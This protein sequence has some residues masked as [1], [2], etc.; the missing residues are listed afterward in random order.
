VTK[1]LARLV[2]LSRFNSWAVWAVVSLQPTLIAFGHEL[3]CHSYVGNR[4]RR[5]IA[6]LVM[7]NETAVPPSS[8]ARD[9]RGARPAEVAKRQD[10]IMTD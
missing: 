1:R 10:M 2:A 7:L 4:R 5:Q 3:D 8:F 6:T 9:D